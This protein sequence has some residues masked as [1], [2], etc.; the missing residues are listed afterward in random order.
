MK[1][2]WY[3]VNLKDRQHDRRLFRREVNIITYTYFAWKQCLSFFRG[4]QQ[5]MGDMDLPPTTLLVV[6]WVKHSNDPMVVHCM[7]FNSNTIVQLNDS[8]SNTPQTTAE[9]IGPTFRLCL[10]PHWNFWLKILRSIY[11]DVTTYVHEN[12]RMKVTR[13]W[14][15]LINK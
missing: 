6:F 3:K 11:S 15:N 5:G 10:S 2:A 7:K 4:A 14:R 13:H 8:I 9:C 1:D 12:M